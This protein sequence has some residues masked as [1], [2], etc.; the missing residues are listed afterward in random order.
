MSQPTELD[1]LSDLEFVEV[2][3][4]LHQSKKGFCRMVEN[5]RIASADANSR[6]AFF[7][8]SNRQKPSLPK[9]KFLESE[10]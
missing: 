5:S 4:P 7:D 3:K 6:R 2:R 9:L 8:D 1:N 10:D